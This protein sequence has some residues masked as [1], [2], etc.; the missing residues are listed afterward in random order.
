VKAA[1]RSAQGY[2]A[3]PFTSNVEACAGLAQRRA[4]ARSWSLSF[5]RGASDRKPCG[6]ARLY[7]DEA[8]RSLL[9]EASAQT[10]A[11]AVCAAIM[12]VLIEQEARV[13]V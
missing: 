5:G 1:A 2:L 8:G 10:P 11:L 4:G 13:H 9:A 6:R 7:A 3:S 12:N